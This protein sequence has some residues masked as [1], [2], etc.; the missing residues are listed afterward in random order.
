MSDHREVEARHRSEMNDLARTLD[1]FF[2]G[3][4]RDG[5]AKVGFVLLVF[6]FGA[7]PGRRVNYISNATDRQEIT[8]LFK[9]MIARFEGQSLT[10][11]TG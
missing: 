10:P 8:S 5:K 4:P 7:A 6:P 11:G 3:P 2:N 9:E 1:A